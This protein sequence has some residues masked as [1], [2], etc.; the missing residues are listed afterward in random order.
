MDDRNTVVYPMAVEFGVCHS[1]QRVAGL[2]LIM[3]SKNLFEE[4]YDGSCGSGTCRMEVVA[5]A[6][7]RP[8]LE[9][10]IFTV[11]VDSIALMPCNPN[12]GGRFKGASGS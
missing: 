11:S 3:N 7:A 9:T 6:C 2:V 5:L 4:T 10:I 8:G 1:N 12:I